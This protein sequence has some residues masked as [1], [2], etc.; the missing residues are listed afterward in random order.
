MSLYRHPR[1]GGDPVSSNSESL[2][3]EHIDLWTSTIK[4]RKTQG[5]GSN[6]KRELYGIKK[7]RELILELAVRGKLVSQDPN[8]EPASV[9]L[10][11]IFAEKAQL[12]KDGKIKKQKVLPDISDEEKP[13]ELPV[14]WTWI[15]N[16]DIFTLT[17]GKKPQ[18]LFESQMSDRYPYLD[19]EALDRGNILRYTDDEKCPRATDKDILVVCDGS[20]SGLLLNG[21]DGV[22]GSTLARIN[23]FPFVQ[24]FVEFF[25]K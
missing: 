21:Q 11:R 25:F 1:V 23:T 16:V 15:K 13:F 8:D 5:R 24:E 3:T 17:K 12:I 2:I 4:A 9:L 7:L 20:R 22:I 14:G 18:N 6:K 10:E 19:I